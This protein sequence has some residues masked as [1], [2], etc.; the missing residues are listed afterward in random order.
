MKLW[1]IV[2][3]WKSIYYDNKKINIAYI[4]IIKS[5]RYSTIIKKNAY[6]HNN[7]NSTYYIIYPAD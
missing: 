3:T 6:S 5:E 4:K 2:A 7:N 1:Q